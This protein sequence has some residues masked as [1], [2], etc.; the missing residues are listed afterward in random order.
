MAKCI[1][2]EDKIGLFEK[3]YNGL[4]ERCN[5]KKNERD[6]LIAQCPLFSPKVKH[7]IG[8]DQQIIAFAFSPD[9]DLLA[10]GGLD[11]SVLLYDFKK[12]KQ[13]C[14][15]E[16]HSK[17]VLALAFSSDGRFL[18]TAGRDKCINVYDMMSRLLVKTLTHHDDWV[19]TVVF[20]SESHLLL[21]AGADR[22]IVA[23]DLD[24][25]K[26]IVKIENNSN[27]DILAISQDGKTIASGDGA[28]H[29]KLWDLGSGSNLHDFAAHDFW[30]SSLAFSKDQ[31][32][33]VSCSRDMY[34]R[35]WNI[36]DKS[37]EKEK[38]ISTPEKRSMFEGAILHPH[39][40]CAVSERDG[41]IAVSVRYPQESPSLLFLNKHELSPIKEIDCDGDSFIKLEFSKDGMYLGVEKNSDLVV[42]KIYLEAGDIDD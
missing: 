40:N 17:A 33:L 16:N 11:G 5:R 2:C 8:N 38:F 28:G 14:G 7:T 12:D 15:F 4:C 37:L 22:Q 36:E 20:A 32:H 42:Y 35:K 6:Q 10:T 1:K 31:K 19:N 34:L 3:N 25:D 24:A 30:I 9:A 18:A 29:I 23:W 21:S 27:V 26:M 39:I 41:M 13:L